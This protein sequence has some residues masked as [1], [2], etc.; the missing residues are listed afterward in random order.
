MQKKNYLLA[1][2]S[3]LMFLTSCND[4]LEFDTLS[5]NLEEGK[6]T[7]T[8]ALNVDSLEMGDVIQLEETDELKALK[9]KLEKI[10]KQR[11]NVFGYNAYDEYFYSNIYAIR[12]MPLTIYARG[13]VGNTR[14]RYFSCDGANKEVVLTNSLS[15]YRQNFF[16][17]V[18]PATTG[19]PYLVYSSASNTPLVVGHYTSNPSNKILFAKPDNGG[20]LYSASWDL[21]P[22][23]TKGYFAIESQSYLGQSDPDNMWTVFNYV[24]EVKNDNKIGYGQYTNKS[25]QEF[26]IKPISRFEVREIIFDENS[27]VITKGEPYPIKSTNYNNPSVEPKTITIT[28]DKSY[29]EKSSFIENL[30][31]I[32]FD[33][34]AGNFQRPTVVANR[35]VLPQ[36]GTP[37]DAVYSP[38]QQNIEKPINFTYQ[39]DAP[40]NCHIEASAYITTYNVSINYVAKAYY[41]G[42]EIK[43]SGTWRGTVL[44]DPKL[45]KPTYVTRFFDLDTN[46][47]IFPY[48]AKKK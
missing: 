1:L 13:V 15:G 9:E 46:E 35:I 45:T 33:K 6:N 21:I 8:K 24:L 20:D 47:E 28:V 14:N 43:L 7:M 29:F 12:E 19:I 44:A 40:E 3:V 30:S 4:A 41:G 37:A 42:R 38:S 10:K 22:S 34:Y 25:Y 26:Q 27:A 39:V 16:I 23:Q 18:L 36:K 32:A 11:A 48:S 2:F 31:S 17:K 5:S